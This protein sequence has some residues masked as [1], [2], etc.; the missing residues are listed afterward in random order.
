MN[1][2]AGGDEAVWPVES[3]VEDGVVRNSRN[4]VH[5]RNDVSGNERIAGRKCANLIAGAVNQA[6]LHPAADEHQAIVEISSGLCRGGLSGQKLWQAESHQAQATDLQQMPAGYG[7]VRSRESVIP[8]CST[9]GRHSLLR[10]I[11]DCFP[12]SLS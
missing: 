11:K 8:V 3:V 1:N 6:G 12:E 10:F 5:R 9:H 2:I 4:M 7:P